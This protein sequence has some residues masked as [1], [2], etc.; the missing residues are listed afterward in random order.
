MDDLTG[1]NSLHSAPQP[2]MASSPRKSPGPRR[3]ISQALDVTGD[4]LE[5]E[6]KPERQIGLDT[7][8]PMPSRFSES[9]LRRWLKR[10]HSQIN[11][12]C[13]IEILKVTH[14]CQRDKDNFIDGW[15]TQ[16][17][18]GDEILGSDLVLQGWLVGRD[19]QAV[20]IQVMHGSDLVLETPVNISR[21]DVLKVVPCYSSACKFGYQVVLNIE[22]LPA[23]SELLL[24]SI[25]QDGRR[26][27]TGSI[28]YYKYG[29]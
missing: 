1:L 3:P 14:L 9:P 13:S 23:Q 11:Q 27:P 10:I 21:P 25:F 15:I 18:R 12:Q 6:L 7:K 28:Y 19:S 2:V 24:Y 29:S 4:Q 26:I 8:R 5:I 16:Y 17:K 20:M 22:R